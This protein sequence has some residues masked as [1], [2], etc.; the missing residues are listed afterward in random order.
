MCAFFIPVAEYQPSLV[1]KDWRHPAI[2]TRKRKRPTKRDSSET[3]NS[4]ISK[5][6]RI[7]PLIPRHQET[8]SHPLLSSY[9]PNVS[10][11]RGY[12]LSRL[13]TSSKSWRRKIAFIPRWSTKQ[14]DEFKERAA[15]SHE[16]IRS[17]THRLEPTRLAGLSKLLDT[18]LVGYT[19]DAPDTC[20]HVI[21]S[22]E[23]QQF[24]QKLRSSVTSSVGDQALTQSDVRMLP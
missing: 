13:P 23:L 8:H 24:S 1:V 14:I 16:A 3:V 21:L 11:L 18:A 22:K 12:L 5:R 19:N 2:M 4:N 9:Y 20:N 6:Q 10:I 17:G 7:A 15:D